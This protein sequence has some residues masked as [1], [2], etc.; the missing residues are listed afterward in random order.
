MDFPSKE[1]LEYCNR[2]TSPVSETLE[3]LARETHLT[4]LMPQMLSG[5][6]Q[7]TFLRAM[8][9]MLSAKV[10][11]EVG[12]YT[13]Y[14][15]ICMADGLAPGGMVHTIEI[16][17]EQAEIINRYT[18]AAGHQN[19]IKL[20]IGDAL[21]ILPRIDGPI[22]FAFLDAKKEDYGVYFDLLR[23]KIRPGGAILADN[24]LWSGKT[25][26]PEGDPAAEA[27]AAYNEK[28]TG[29]P[30]FFSVLIPMRD[31]LMLSVKK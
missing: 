31:G 11:V 29:D 16:N 1:I 9:A 26:Q 19:S 12:T 13:G 20:H 17:P 3:S 7:G 28:V 8:V 30:E 27:L 6:H 22:D 18:K 23:D 5:Q 21:E 10:V 15:A 24:V 2:V 25:L 14:A 4:R